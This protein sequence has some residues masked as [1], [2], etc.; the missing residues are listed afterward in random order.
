M[1]HNRYLS[2][3]MPMKEIIAVNDDINETTNDTSIEVTLATTSFQPIVLE[4]LFLLKQFNAVEINSYLKKL[5]REQCANDALQKKCFDHSQPQI[6]W[7]S[8]QIWAQNKRLSKPWQSKKL[9]LN[10]QRKL[11]NHYL[12]ELTHLSGSQAYGIA[13]KAAN[14]LLNVIES[15]PSDYLSYFE[16][17]WL[18]LNY[19]DNLAKAEHFFEVAIQKSEKQHPAFAGFAKRHLAHIYYLQ[20]EYRIAASTLLDVLND[21]LY[22]EPEHQYE[23]ARYLAAA[24]EHDLAKLYLEQTVE[25]TP[26]YLLFAQNEKDF[27][28]IYDLDEF[29]ECY[30]QETLKNITWE[31]ERQWFESDL[32]RLSLPQDFDSTDVFNEILKEEQSQIKQQPLLLLKQEEKSL[33]KKLLNKVQTQLLTMLE[34]EEKNYLERIQQKNIQWRGINKIGGFL[35]HTS[36]VLLLAIFF[37]LMGKVIILGLGLGNTFRFDE[38]IGQVF[39]LVLLLA[40]AGAYLFQL[41]PLGMKKLFKQTHRFQSAIL[42]VR[43]GIKE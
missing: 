21:D 5:L 40:G 9:S 4:Y 32:A 13:E 12:Y 26:I 1:S 18:N 25:K 37:V 27:L 30:H 31:A 24:G 7:L 15:H 36:V 8:K 17:A 42:D 41:K 29:L 19:L 2:L 33:P 11:A 28:S 14:I 3:A 6:F 16:I 35:L 43:Q 22:P 34:H 20:T 10:R 38:T 23:Y 39:I